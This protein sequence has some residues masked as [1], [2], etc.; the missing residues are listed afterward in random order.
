MLDKRPNLLPK[1][2]KKLLKRP[3]TIRLNWADRSCQNK[4]L[5][6]TYRGL[7]WFHVTLWFY[8]IPFLFLAA[9][10]IMPILIDALEYRENAGK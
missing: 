5:Y 10:Y 6:A 8:S 1:Q 2:K 4:W 7:R 3:K 9:M